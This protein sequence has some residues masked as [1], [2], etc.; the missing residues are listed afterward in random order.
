MLAAGGVKRLV[1]LPRQRRQEGARF[2]RRR[3]QPGYVKVLGPALTLLHQQPAYVVETTHLAA[4]APRAT[5][6]RAV[7]AERFSQ[8]IG[9]PSLQ[10]LLQWRLQLAAE[11][12]AKGHENRATIGSRVG[13]E[14]EAAFNPAFDGLQVFR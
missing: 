3:H 5:R 7:L 12:L 10:H 13:Y 14:S 1:R 9:V 4:L 6:T 2:D 11:Q 8:A